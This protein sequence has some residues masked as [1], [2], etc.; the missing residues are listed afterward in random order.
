MTFQDDNMITIA[1]KRGETKKKKQKQHRQ[2][3]I[4]TFIRTTTQALT[5]DPEMISRIDREKREQNAQLTIFNHIKL[6]HHRQTKSIIQSWMFECIMVWPEGKKLSWNF[7]CE[8]VHFPI[9]IHWLFY[10]F[11]RCQL[12]WTEED[13]L[14]VSA[15]EPINFDL[16]G[17]CRKFAPPFIPGVFGC[18]FVSLCHMFQ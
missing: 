16:C 1:N 3:N 2:E 10:L 11:S 4:H 8:N 13:K 7:L 9:K 15:L 17:H 12:H 14:F 6:P 5:M 18:E